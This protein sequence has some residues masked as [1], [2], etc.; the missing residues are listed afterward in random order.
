M[1]PVICKTNPD[2]PWYLFQLMFQIRGALSFFSPRK[3]SMKVMLISRYSRTAS[4]VCCASGWHCALSCG[5]RALLTSEVAVREFGLTVSISTR[6]SAIDLN[7]LDPEWCGVIVVCFCRSD[8]ELKLTAFLVCLQR[9]WPV[10]PWH[11]R[12]L[13]RRRVGNDPMLQTLFPPGIWF[14]DSASVIRLLLL[15]PHN[16]PMRPMVLSF[17]YLF[18]LKHWNSVMDDEFFFV[19]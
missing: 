4:W 19:C 14:C 18:F 5:Q 11:G 9:N 3:L 16:E 13:T 12:I 17:V 10:V 7:S 8:A 1:G 15:L 2:T 6:A